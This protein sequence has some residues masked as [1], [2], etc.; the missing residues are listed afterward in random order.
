MR[1]NVLTLTALAL[2]VAGIAC[3]PAGKEVVP[4]DDSAITSI[5][6]T[7]G[8]NSL[9]VG[10]TV[11][12]TAIARNAAGAAVAGHAVTWA[13]APSSVATIGSTSGVLTAV[14]AGTAN[15][16]ATIGSVT[17]TATVT[18]ADPPPAPVATVSVNPG[19]Y[20]LTVGGT[21]QLSAT[22]RDANGAVLTGRAITWSSSNNG[23]ATVSASGPNSRR[24][25]RASTASLRTVDVP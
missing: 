14:G 3:F 11:A 12:L 22:T 25:Q 5:V 17:G 10:S 15:V 6:V 18:V 21:V 1:T 24:T 20:T 8:S 7:P 2:G 13:A 16:T 4:P 9:V 23:Y 19:S